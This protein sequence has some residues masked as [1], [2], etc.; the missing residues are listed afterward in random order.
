MN[1]NFGLCLD[2]FASADPRPSFDTVVCGPVGLLRLLELRLGLVGAL[3]SHGRRVVGYQGRRDQWAA[4][5]LTFS[6]QL[7]LYAQ[8]IGRAHV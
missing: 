3:P 6:G 5:A 7:A 4:K 2:G 8:E 1:V